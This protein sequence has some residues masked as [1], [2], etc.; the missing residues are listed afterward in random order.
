MKL[1]GH[2]WSQN[3]SGDLKD[4]RRDRSKLWYGRATWWPFGLEGKRGRYSLHTEWMV[5]SKRFDIG[6][7]RVH[8]HIGVTFAVPGV[9]LFLS[10]EGVPEPAWDKDWAFDVRI[11]DKGIWWNLGTPVMSWSSKTPRWRNGTWKPLD[12]I[13]GRIKLIEEIVLEQRDVIIEVAAGEYFQGTAELTRSVWK[14]KR[15][16]KRMV[17]SR[18]TIE[19]P[20]GLPIPGKGE[21]AWDCD[22]DA[23]FSSTMVAG[24]ISEAV[25]LL[26]AGAKRRRLK[27]G[28]VGWQPR[29]EATL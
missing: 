28:G 27:H 5:G 18:V 20:S 6:I 12:T 17:L 11:F 1:L 9:S 14:R 10:L 23:I 26:V 4:W 21:N 15:L 2:F 16:P 13:F 3:L 22:E 19:V 25:D 8:D 29:Q 7:E 24:S